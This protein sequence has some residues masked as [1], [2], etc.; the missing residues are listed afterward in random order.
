MSGSGMGAPEPE[1]VDQTPRRPRRSKD[2]ADAEADLGHHFVTLLSVERPVPRHFADQRGMLPV[3][4]EANADWRQSGVIFDRNQPH[5]RAVRLC[6]MALPS[7]EH[8]GRLKAALDEALHGREGRE[9]ADPLRHRFRNGVDFGSFD[10]WWG[11][12]LSD[13]VA[14]CELQASAFEVFGRAEHE[15]RVAAAVQREAARRIRGGR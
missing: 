15:M 8:A 2:E 10:H 1:Y 14:M 4:V 13:A 11:P 9:D 12:L 5:L 7:A 3:W 6:V